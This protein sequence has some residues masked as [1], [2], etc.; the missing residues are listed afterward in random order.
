MTRLLVDAEQIREFAQGMF[1]YASDD[2]V[3]SLRVFAD[4]GGNH[5]LNIQFVRLNGEGLEPLIEAAVAQAQ[6]AADHSEK[7][8]FCSPVCGF[9]SETSAKEDDLLEGY[10]LS[11]EC[12]Q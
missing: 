12:D 5:P 4:A 2:A 9:S 6:L 8:V 7:A 11:V 1:A 10:A 3:I